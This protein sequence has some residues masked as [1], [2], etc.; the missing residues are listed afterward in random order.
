MILPGFTQFETVSLPASGDGPGHWVTFLTCTRPLHSCG[1]R[2]AVVS[3][4]DDGADRMFCCGCGFEFR[5]S[6]SGA[7]G[8]SPG[9]Q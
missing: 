9:Q 2:F 7:A 6:I 3:R 4:L 5:D 8:G 1:S